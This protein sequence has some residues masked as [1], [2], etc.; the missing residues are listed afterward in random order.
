[1]RRF[2]LCKSKLKLTTKCI[3]KF[4][5][6]GTNVGQLSNSSKP[7]KILILFS[8]VLITIVIA[9]ANF[10]FGL[11]VLKLHYNFFISLLVLWQTIDNYSE[12]NKEMSSWFSS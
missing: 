9:A 8:S 12:C 1:M 7:L 4:D 6:Q 2:F 11:L 3:I 10:A 5:M